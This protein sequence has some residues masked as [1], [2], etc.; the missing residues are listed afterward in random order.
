M[1]LTQNQGYYVPPH[2]RQRQLTPST[3]QIRETNLTAD[4]TSTATNP[5]SM[6]AADSVSG[7]LDGQNSPQVLRK[8]TNGSPFKRHSSTLKKTLKESSTAM[9]RSEAPKQPSKMPSQKHVTQKRQGS[10]WIKN[11]DLPKPPPAGSD[12]W[13]SDDET[14]DNDNV[15]S[16]VADDG[17][18]TP[19]KRAEDYG[20]YNLRDWDGNWAPAPVDWEERG[21]FKDRAWG[22]RLDQW[23]T[24]SA[25]IPQD[26]VDLKLEGAWC[27]GSGDLAPKPWVPE[28]IDGISVRKWWSGHLIS[29]LYDGPPD[30]KPWWERYR[31][32]E[33]Q[34]L[35]A[36]V[37]PPTKGPNPH[38]ETQALREKRGCDHG[39]EEFSLQY[40]E[41]LERKKD[42]WQQLRAQK[43]RDDEN[44]R[45]RDEERRKNPKPFYLRPANESHVHSITEIY[46]KHLQEFL[47][48]PELQSL[49]ETDMKN[50]Y[51]TVCDAMLPFLVALAY[52]SEGDH[53]AQR[54]IDPSPNDQVIGFAYASTFGQ[55]NSVFRHAATLAIYV[56]P[57][58][59]KKKV[60][61][62]LMDRMSLMLSMSFLPSRVSHDFYPYGSPLGD[63]PVRTH[64]NVIVQVT[65]AAADDD[66]LNWMTNWLTKWEFTSVGVYKGIGMKLG[67]A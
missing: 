43:L 31:S 13:N 54:C 51:T 8:A 26:K 14:E 23:L 5:N 6:T 47:H 3:P 2:R 38:E 10:I 52:S 37:N 25:I 46:N 15:R 12:A 39:S 57:N 32:D 9:Q 50:R 34:L 4:P 7:S 56:D 45:K 20:G 49:T 64:S 42:Q 21:C 35:A 61:N 11:R 40:M 27:E 19:R 58:H 33:S 28:H 29:P 30:A 1:A 66:Y 36:V 24:H 55:E 22:E 53:P 63:G 48:C 67:K 65:Y 16:V 62:A 17:C 18:G 60:G 41:K 44:Q 59:Y